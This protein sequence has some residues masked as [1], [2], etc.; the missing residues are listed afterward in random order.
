MD[1]ATARWFLRDRYLDVEKARAKII[2][3][4]RWRRNFA[5]STRLADTTREASSRKGY[6][7]GE[8]SYPQSHTATDFHCHHHNRCLFPTQTHHRRARRAGQ[9][10]NCGGRAAPLA[11]DAQAR[12]SS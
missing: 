11:S 7:H 12:Y 5:E 4:T 10:R 9:A 2:A 8:L 6:L 1:P 3:R